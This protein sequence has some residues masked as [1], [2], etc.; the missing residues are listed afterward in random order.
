MKL[1]NEM[2]ARAVGALHP[3][4]FDENGVRKP[5]VSPTH[6][7]LAVE[8]VQRALEAA[9]HAASAEYL[10]DLAHNRV[11]AELGSRPTFSVE[12]ERRIAEL[13][14][15]LEKE[16]LATQRAIR[17]RNTEGA[18]FMRVKAENADLAAKNEELRRR[19]QARTE[20]DARAGEKRSLPSDAPDV[21]ELLKLIEPV[22]E[23]WGAIKKAMND[24]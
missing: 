22:G 10:M 24:K 4:K 18:H 20:E 5:G 3:D 12:N 23:L 9:M 19:L 8:G 13:E 7:D 15:A 21:T 2:V 16:K 14:T 1:T 17:D 6:A 11:L